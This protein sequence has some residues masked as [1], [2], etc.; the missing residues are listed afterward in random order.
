[1]DV[2]HNVFKKIEITLHCCKTH[3]NVII[4]SFNRPARLSYV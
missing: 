4:L 3:G 2:T 1:M